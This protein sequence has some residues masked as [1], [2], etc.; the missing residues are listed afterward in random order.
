MRI[1]LSN[2]KSS[3]DSN[4][5]VNILFTTDNGGVMSF[6]M[7]IENMYYNLMPPIVKMANE[8]RAQ[9]R[10]LIDSMYGKDSYPAIEIFPIQIH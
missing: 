1:K 2:A 4:D 10:E 3:I 5:Y 9:L 6:S 8:N 7:T